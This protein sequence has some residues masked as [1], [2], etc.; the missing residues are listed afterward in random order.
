VFVDN[1]FNKNVHFVKLSLM[2]EAP[3]TESFEEIVEWA[4]KTLPQKV[5]DQPDFPGIQVAD[6]PPEE[7]LKA[8]NWPPGIEMLGCYSG[9]FR[10][11]RRHTLIGIAPD[12]IFVFRGPILRCSKGDLRAEVKRVVGTRSHIG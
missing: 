12:W 11:K 2:A 1:G 9:V 7:I 10:T 3:K 8:K 4:Y 6:E 5:T